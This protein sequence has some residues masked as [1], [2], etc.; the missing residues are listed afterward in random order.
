MN[1]KPFVSGLLAGAV[2]GVMLTLG[3]STA[4]REVP[5]PPQVRPNLVIKAAPLTKES[6]PAENPSEEFLNPDPLFVIP[7]SPDGVPFSPGDEHELPPDSTRHFF[8]GRPYY[9]VPLAMS[10]TEKSAG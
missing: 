2:F 3:L 7:Y 8:N 5:E 10:I 1:R 9:V 6:K 4:F